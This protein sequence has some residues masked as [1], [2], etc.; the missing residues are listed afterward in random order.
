V[1]HNQ[2]EQIQDQEVIQVKVELVKVVVYLNQLVDLHQ[3]KVR[4]Q[5]LDP[6]EEMIRLTLQ[7]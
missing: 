7:E 2:E 5:V 1:Q 3:L 6:L 4:V